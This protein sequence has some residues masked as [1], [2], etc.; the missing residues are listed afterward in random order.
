MCSHA[1]ASNIAACPAQLLAT[2]IVLFLGAFIAGLLPLSL[3]LTDKQLRLVTALGAGMLVGVALA[4]I[5]PEGFDAFADAQEDLG[6]LK[7]A[8]L[9]A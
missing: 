5:V 2:C 9:G 6:E 4:V 8:S 7:S 3:R 1:C